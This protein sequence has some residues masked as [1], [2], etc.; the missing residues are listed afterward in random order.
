[1]NKSKIHDKMHERMNDPKCCEN[2]GRQLDII[3]WF[4]V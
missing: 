1:M 3:V 4:L 2:L